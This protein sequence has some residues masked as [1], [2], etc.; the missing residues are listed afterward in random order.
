MHNITHAVEGNDLVIRIPLTPDAIR[1]APP[2][3]T[4]KTRLVGSSSGYIGVAAPNVKGAIAF[5][6]TVTVKG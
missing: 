5:S 6:A 1:A 2:S 3:S 4:G